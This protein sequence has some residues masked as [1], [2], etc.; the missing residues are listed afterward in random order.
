ML[1]HSQHI[2]GSAAAWRNMSH[3]LGTS[4][5]VFLVLSSVSLIQS[6][7]FLALGESCTKCYCGVPDVFHIPVVFIPTVLTKHL[8]PLPHSKAGPKQRQVEKA[9]PEHFS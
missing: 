3:A 2:P 8:F 9:A 6:F 5:R 4:C 7:P 1:F